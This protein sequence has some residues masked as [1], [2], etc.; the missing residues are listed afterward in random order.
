MSTSKQLHGFPLLLARTA[1]VTMA[2]MILVLF[3]IGIPPEYNAH[4]E[5]ATAEFQPELAQLRLGVQFYAIYRTVLDSI[6]AIAFVGIGAII[7][8]NK[9]NDWLVILVSIANMT[10][11]TLFVPTLLQIIQ[12]HPTLTVPVGL[13][14]SAGLGLSLIVLYYLFPDGRFVPRWVRW[15]ALVWAV[16]AITWFLF[17]Q[18]PANLV[19]LDSWQ[20]NMT[21][22]YSTFLIAYSSG[23]ASQFIRYRK[24]A[25]PVQRQQTKWVVFGTTT[26][27]LGF[28][29]YHIPLVFF[30]VFNENSMP[31]LI[32]ILVGIPIYHMMI[33]A[34]PVAIGHSMMKFRLWEID[35]VIN[36]SLLS[37]AMSLIL[38][39]VYFVTVAF[40]GSLLSTLTGQAYPGF[41]T[42]ISTLAVA[43]LF[44]P[45]RN[46]L[47]VA[48]DRRFYRRK[49]DTIR[50][51]DSFGN[52]VRN[53][54][55]LD[56]L[57]DR[58]VQV[59]TETMQPTSMTVWLP[60]QRVKRIAEVQMLDERQA[61]AVKADQA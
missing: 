27:F 8:F 43:G 33:L 9:S 47:Q 51:L 49:Y 48:I 44:N 2:L 54:V 11:G 17:P 31:R 56:L 29:L 20:Q 41:V 34:A 21:L 22:S 13:M 7:F 60:K 1:W 12:T 55:N 5:T 38:G 42:V 26:A 52:V 59:V 10:F 30:P 15:P 19:Y 46:R 16:L 23:I 61:T 50:T 28:V 37:G 58:L 4:I 3:A 24:V 35:L 57:T 25:N 6:V 53:E 40:L 32:Q 18:F 14:R 36:R 45:V 39:L